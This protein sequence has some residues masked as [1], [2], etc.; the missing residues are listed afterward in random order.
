MEEASSG[1]A[2][3]LRRGGPVAGRAGGAAEGLA[4]RPR[5]VDRRAGAWRLLLAVALGTG[6]LLAR[7]RRSDAR[8]TA[9]ILLALW[10]GT[11]VLRALLFPF[12]FF[13]PNGQGAFWIGFALDEGG[14]DWAYGPGFRELFGWVAGRPEASPE[15]LVFGAQAVGGATSAAC[16]WVLGRELGGRRLLAWVGAAVVAA[17]PILARVSQSQS[18]YATW[19]S[20]LFLAAAVLAAGTPR[21]GEGR[22]SFALAVS[23]AGLLVAQA[24]RV[25]PIGWLSAAALPLI[26]FAGRGPLRRRLLLTGAAAGG[27][28]LVVAAASG[29]A[30]WGVLQGSLGARWLPEV[31]V[32]GLSDPG[33][34]LSVAPLVVV[35]VLASRDRMRAV[36]IAAALL[37]TA[38]WMDRMC[39]VRSDPAPFQRAYAAMWAPALLGLSVALA[40]GLRT[41]TLRAVA[42][43]ALLGLALVGYGRT[44]RGDRELSTTELEALWAEEWRGRLPAGSTVVYLSRVGPHVLSLPL[45]GARSRV[46]VEPWTLSHEDALPALGHLGPD[47]YYY[48]SSLCASREARDFCGRLRARHALERVEERTLPARAGAGGAF[49]EG[50]AVTVGLFRVR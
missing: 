11:L 19:T 41:G 23:S 18:Y 30:M 20:L 22:L 42:A 38:Y 36:L 3:A 49:F 44:L 35:V 48:E 15:R 28:A 14:P 1:E 26:V 27:I 50:A 39:L 16:A 40:G 31:R 5:V 33:A 34:L 37:A 45:Y 21:P 43:A 7:P 12:A 32:A 47:T 8:R 9:A 29:R 2:G 4:G 13:H 46:G 10:A 24:A 6:A 17:S 25:T